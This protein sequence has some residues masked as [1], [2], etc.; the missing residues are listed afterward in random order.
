MAISTTSPQIV[1]DDGYF[2]IFFLHTLSDL[3]GGIHLERISKLTMS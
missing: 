3:S 2:F 1:E